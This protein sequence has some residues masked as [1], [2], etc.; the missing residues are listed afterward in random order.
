MTARTRPAARRSRRR[1]GRVRRLVAGDRLYLF[2]L[3]V[4][5]LVLGLMAASP[6]QSYT[7]AA[8]RTDQLD[9]SVERLR[10]EVTELEEERDRLQDPDEIELLARSEHGMVR[11]GEV[12]F[13]VVTPE[14]E[15]DRPDPDAGEDPDGLPWHERLWV[16]V[17]DL[18]R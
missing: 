11:P 16:T 8:D 4:V 1:G 14:P 12:P 15:F 6:L 17:T 10:A 13:V 18:F 5:I 3:F 9:A 2:I 7:V